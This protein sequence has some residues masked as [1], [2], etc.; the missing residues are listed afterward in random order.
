M[1]RRGKIKARQSVSL[2]VEAHPM[3][4]KLVNKVMVSGKKEIARRLIK[5]AF[6][7]IGKET[8]AD[9]VE[10]YLQVLERVK[11]RV[12]VR[13]RQVG[14]AAYQVPALVRGKRQESLALR[15]I[16]ASARQRSSKEY[17]T[18]ADKLAAEILDAHKGVGGAISKREEVEKIAEANRAFAHLR[19]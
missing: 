7:R 13:S 15:W 4:T 1:S 8:K 9:P 6:A 12:E 18:F 19:W 17:H 10:I 11:P 16:I 2:T 14:G 3:V 5:N